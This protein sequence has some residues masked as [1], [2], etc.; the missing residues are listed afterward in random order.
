MCSRPTEQLTDR[1]VVIGNRHFAFVT[2]GLTVWGESE[3][4]CRAVY[5]TETTEGVLV[6]PAIVNS[7][8]NTAKPPNIG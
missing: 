2:A 1:V 4:A 3:V 7:T 6:R 8:H 5:G